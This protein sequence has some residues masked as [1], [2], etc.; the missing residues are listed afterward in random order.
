MISIL[1]DGPDSFSRDLVQLFESFQADRVRLLSIVREMQLGAQLLATLEG[2]R[3]ARKS[4]DDDP[5][6]AALGTRAATIL[7]R[8]GALDVEIEV[9]SIRVPGVSGAETLIHGRVT[10]EQRIAAGGANAV[11]VDEKHQPVEGVEPVEIDDAGYYAFVV[12]PDVVTK[13]GT[14]RKL[15]IQ[16]EREGVRIVPATANVFTI[17]AG[18]VAVN[19]V[20]LSVGEMDRLKL[21]PSFVVPRAVK[22]AGAARGRAAMGMKKT[23]AAVGAARG[24]APKKKPRPQKK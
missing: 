3:L 16:V 13:I 19:D 23:R 22:G 11:L 7:E 21:R 17:G 9:A 20:A 1:N 8:V 10:D 6:V 12:K 18:T 14:D 15:S 2:Q 24:R 5:R 4:G